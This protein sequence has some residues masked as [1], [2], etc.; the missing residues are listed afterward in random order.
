MTAHARTASSSFRLIDQL[1]RHALAVGVVLVLMLPAARGSHAWLG[2][3]PMWL[4]GMP[5]VAWW[6]L[7]RF[8]LPRRVK[9]APLRPVT[10]RVRPVQARRRARVSHLKSPHRRAA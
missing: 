2:W 8:A 4:V 3:L 10:R 7:H 1:L 9:A 6:A 5:L